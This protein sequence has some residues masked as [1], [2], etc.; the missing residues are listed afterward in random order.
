MGCALATLAF[1]DKSINGIGT[2]GK[3]PFYPVYHNSRVETSLYGF[4]CPPVGDAAFLEAWQP[5]SYDLSNR[6]WR[7]VHGLD[8]VNHIGN[9]FHLSTYAQIPREVYYPGGGK[10]PFTVCDGTG[11]DRDCSASNSFWIGSWNMRDHYRYLGHRMGC[12]AADNQHCAFPDLSKHYRTPY[13]LGAAAEVSYP[14][15]WALDYQ[16]Q[17][18]PMYVAFI[19]CIVF[20]TLVTVATV[21]LGVC[22]AVRCCPEF[23]EQLMYKCKGVC[24]KARYIERKRSR[25]KLRKLITPDHERSWVQI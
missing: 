22:A 24:N 21:V 6:T 1:F 11:E 2:E 15:V 8:L 3:T 14:F 18:N 4:G 25:R 10:E 19:A 17:L 5:E 13:P 7:V 9:H 12:C 20:I 23:F 16:H